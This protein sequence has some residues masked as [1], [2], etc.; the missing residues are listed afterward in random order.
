VNIDLSREPLGKDKDGKETFLRDL[1]PNLS[2]IKKTMQSAL[3]PET[4]RKLYRDF[5]DQ[6]PKWNEIPSSAGDIYEWDEK[7]DYIHEPPF[8]ENFSMKP[9]HIEEIRG[10]RAL[11]IFGD[12][13][14]TDHISPAGAIKATSPA[15]QY[16][17]SRGIEPADFNSY[18]SRR[19][20]DLV[21]TRG[22]FANVRI[23]NL[24]VPGTE[25]GITLHQPSGEQMSIFDAAMKYAETKT[26]LII[27]AGNEYGT[28]SS[29]DWAAKGTRLLGVK[30]VVAAS[31]E[32]IHRSNLVGMG[33]LPLQF[34]DGTT[35]QSL[36]LD[37]S[38]IFSITGL[39]NEVKPG[40][41]VTLEIEGKGA[42]KRSV[43]L[44]L[45][46]DTPIEIDYYRHGG[47]LPYV[48]R[49]LLARK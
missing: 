24:M 10:A 19:G 23:K 34:P 37:G 12:S 11:G 16:L 5:A 2:E 20:N 30:A 42:Q 48:L 33:V 36:G 1:W 8:F 49:Q 9:G 27:L 35:A 13:V 43:P 39:S 22:T 38:E 6:N 29:R 47:I 7:S 44:K 46:I 17:V 3:R 26:P 4:F 41:N 25:G 45:R 18:G 21:M 32:R 15:G 31:F 40:R 28:G 14:T